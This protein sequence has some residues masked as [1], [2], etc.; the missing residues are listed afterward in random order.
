MNTK[1]ENEIS[2]DESQP[3]WDSLKKDV[4]LIW[5]SFFFSKSIFTF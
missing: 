2:E 1:S 5:S 4:P 3:E